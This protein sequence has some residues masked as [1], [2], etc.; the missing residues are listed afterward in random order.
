MA[1]SLTAT[2]RHGRRQLRPERRSRDGPQALPPL[3][4]RRRQRYRGPADFAAFR[5]AYGSPSSTFD[6]DGN[7]IVDQADFS[8]FRERMARWCEWCEQRFAQIRAAWDQESGYWGN[9]GQVSRHQ[10]RCWAD[11]N[12][13]GFSLAAPNFVQNSCTA[14]HRGPTTPKHLGRHSAFF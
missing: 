9:R 14:P 5:N 4:R 7:N 3:R 10:L 8:A 6:N 1:A 2:R 13:G 11:E 12:G